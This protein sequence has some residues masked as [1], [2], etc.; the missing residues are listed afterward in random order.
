MPPAPP[1]VSGGN[2]ELNIKPEWVSSPIREIFPDSAMVMVV[3]HW[4]DK[5]EEAV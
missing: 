1:G 2:A 5:P 4:I 3:Y